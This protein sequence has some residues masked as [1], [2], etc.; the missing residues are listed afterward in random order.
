[1]PHCM[2]GPHGSLYG[3]HASLYGHHGSLYGPHASL[4]GPHASLYCRFLWVDSDIRWRSGRSLQ[5]A[6]TQPLTRSLSFVRCSLCSLPCSLSLSSLSCSLCSVCSAHYYADCA[7]CARCAAQVP[8]Q[9][10][11][12]IGFDARSIGPRSPCWHPCHNATLIWAQAVDGGTPHTLSISAR[13]SVY[14]NRVAE[15][16]S[17]L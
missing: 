14:L 13:Q 10:S 5:L 8:L 3:P 17:L 9:E 6:G 1:M 7:D 2:V 11:V 12:P 16:D 15:I 4:Y